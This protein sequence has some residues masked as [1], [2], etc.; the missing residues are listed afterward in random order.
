MVALQDRCSFPTLSDGIKQ[1]FTT[2]EKTTDQLEWENYDDLRIMRDGHIYKEGGFSSFQE[3]CETD[4]S[5]WGGYRRVNQLIQAKEVRNALRGTELEGAVTNE[6]QARPVAK[7]LK[8]PDKADKIRQVVALAKQNN[9]NPTSEDFAKAV[10]QVLPKK[11]KP[12]P[13]QNERKVKEP[14]FFLGVK[15]RVSSQTHPLYGQEGEISGDPPNLQQ[16][17]VQFA[18][19]REMIFNRDLTAVDE[20]RGSE[21]EG[22]RDENLPSALIRKLPPEYEEAIAQLKQQHREEVSRLENELRVGL[23]SQAQSVAVLEVK[24]QLDAA[25][26]IARRTKEENIA[27]QQRLDEL[28]SL[29]QLEVENQRLQQD[30]EEL[31][32]QLQQKPMQRWDTSDV[33]VERLNKNVQAAIKNTIDLRSLA[34]EPPKEDAEECLRLMGMALGNLAKALN[35]S[36]AMSAAATI[37]KCEPNPSAIASSIERNHLVNQAVIDIRIELSK[38]SGWEDLYKVASEYEQIKQDYWDKLDREEKELII[39]LKNSFEDSTQT[40]DEA[41]FPAF[42]PILVGAIVSHSDKYSTMYCQQGIV[43][44][45]ID[46][47]EVKV[48]WNEDNEQRPKRYFKT[49]LRLRT[50]TI[51]SSSKQTTPVPS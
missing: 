13:P 1:R 32:N 3:Y 47:E 45:E 28:E 25:N 15:V 34:L 17:F 18:E 31:R 39:Q 5:Q 50:S 23:L 6:R 27:L 2:I 11:P 14:R 38:G 10:L 33:V 49:D 7:L 43:I 21:A 42:S 26:A 44:E 16:Q 24:E 30:N 4:L 35:D 41:E 29:R 46:D 36:A 9:E 19:T 12:S 8:F 51:E 22:R 20:G 40:D 37:L 48:L